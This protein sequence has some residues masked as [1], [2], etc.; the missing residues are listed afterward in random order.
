[1]ALTDVV[2]L[3]QNSFKFCV[4][5]GK[6]DFSFAAEYCLLSHKSLDRETNHKVGLFNLKDVIFLVQNRVEFCVDLGKYDFSFAAE[7]CLLSNKSLD[8]ETNLKVGLFNYTPCSD[9]AL[10]FNVKG[11]LFLRIFPIYFQFVVKH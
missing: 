10:S 4:D 5:L 1:M 6:Y 3:F 7:Y 9:N 2:L 11:R 8:R